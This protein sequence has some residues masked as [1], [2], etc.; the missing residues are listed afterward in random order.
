MSA[1]FISSA[2]PGSPRVDHAYAILVID[3]H[4]YVARAGDVDVGRGHRV[5]PG[6]SSHRRRVATAARGIVAYDGRG[7][8]A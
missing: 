5:Q 3:R 2:V 7:A 8:G 1:D 4:V 6:V